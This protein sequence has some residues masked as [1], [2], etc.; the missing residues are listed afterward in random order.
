VL[1]EDGV[2]LKAV[3][4]VDDHSR[5]CLAVGRVERATCRPVCRV[6]ARTLAQFGAPEAVLTDN[7]KVRGQAPRREIVDVHVTDRLLEVWSGNELIRTLL[8]ASGG[9]IRK[10]RAERMT[11]RPPS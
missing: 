11:A 5:F 9:E 2:E 7:G 4:A 6:F 1:L 10:K 8:R 3:T